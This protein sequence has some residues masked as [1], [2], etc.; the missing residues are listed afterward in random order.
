TPHLTYIMNA[1]KAITLCV[2]FLGLV[3]AAKCREDTDCPEDFFC[4]RR[5]GVCISWGIGNN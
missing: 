2:L 1:I 5:T 3:S 4:Q